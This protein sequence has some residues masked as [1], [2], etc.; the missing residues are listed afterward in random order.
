MVAFF[1]SKLQCYQIVKFSNY[2]KLFIYKNVK[3]YVKRVLVVL[4]VQ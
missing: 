3:E 1:C 4:K 2:F